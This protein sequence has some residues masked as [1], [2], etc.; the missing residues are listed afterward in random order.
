ME[1]WSVT[2]PQ[3]SPVRCQT[4]P[5]N[6]SSIVPAS[7]ASRASHTGCHPAAATAYESATLE[8]PALLRLDLDDHGLRGLAALRLDLLEVGARLRDLPRELAPRHLGLADLLRALL[9]LARDVRG[10]LGP[11]A[12]RSTPRTA[13]FFARSS[14]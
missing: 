13:R 11:L 4:E 2:S 12:A 9:Q 10:E 1:T 8:R 7:G 6:A 3:S 14:E 5:K